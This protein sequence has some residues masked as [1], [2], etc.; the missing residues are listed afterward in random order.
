MDAVTGTS[1]ISFLTDPDAKSGLF[2]IRKMHNMP[3]VQQTDHLG[4]A[5]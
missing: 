3:F 1:L 2:I 5:I 4:Y